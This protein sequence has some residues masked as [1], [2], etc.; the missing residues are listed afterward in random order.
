MK[1]CKVSKRKLIVLNEKH[2]KV[3]N[4][5][6]TIQLFRLAYTPKFQSCDDL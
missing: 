3:F 1:I 2:S 6:E 5:N 4:T